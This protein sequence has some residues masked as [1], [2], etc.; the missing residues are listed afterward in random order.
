M[1]IHVSIH[2]LGGRRVILDLFAGPG[3]WSE[4]LRLLGLHDVGVEW[5]DAACRTRAA[6]GHVTVEAD[7]TKLH[8]QTF[9]RR[10]L[11]V[12]K[13]T[14]LIESPACP[15]FSAAGNGAGLDDMP[16]LLDLLVGYGRGVDMRELAVV[17]DDR[18]LLS[19]EPARWALALEP[20]WVACE[21]VP[22][23]LPV[24][25][26]TAALLRERGYSTWTGVLCAANYGVGQERY[27]AF[28]MASRVRTVVPPAPTYAEHPDPTLFGAPLLPWPTMAQVLGWGM[29]ARPSMT[30]T[31]GGTE[32][33]GAEPFGRGARDAME[34]ERERSA[35]RW[36]H[37]NRDQRPDGSRQ[38]VDASA[39]PSP[40][41]TAKSGGQWVFRRPATTVC[42]DPRLA[43]P[44]HRDRAGGQRQY[45]DESV[46]LTVAEAAAL[47]SFRPGYPWQGT[48]TKQHEQVGNAVRPLL[49]AAVVGELVG[50]DWRSVLWPETGAA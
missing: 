33:G 42:A 38:V 8:P 14:G 19:V 40:T 23:A 44:G 29:S 11:G 12:R 4:G 27:R 20:E 6:A 46:R 3:G 1:S 41:L 16:T 21:Q 18:S 36:L 37:T 13:V 28:L 9:V 24:W 34:R 2:E 7:V 15:P 25:E 48:K 39:R 50:L 45:D 32:R 31:G 10:S 47:Q 22:G 49:A 30:V 17:R 43:G 35:G 5:D 26:A